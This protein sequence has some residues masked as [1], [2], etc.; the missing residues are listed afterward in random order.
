MDVYPVGK[1]GFLGLGIERASVGVLAA[2]V[3]DGCDAECRAV[4]AAPND[5]RPSE[6]SQD[7]V[8]GQLHDVDMQGRWELLLPIDCIALVASRSE[9]IAQT[10]RAAE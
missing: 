1:R 7:A 8:G 5:V 9:R 6:L 3:S 4:V 10:F 2:V